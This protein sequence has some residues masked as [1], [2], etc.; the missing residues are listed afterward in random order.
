[1]GCQKRCLEYVL[2]DA[3]TQDPTGALH[4][5]EYLPLVRLPASRARCA[6]DSHLKRYA[7]GMLE[8][9]AACNNLA[10]PNV[11]FRCEGFHL[12]HI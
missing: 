10:C 2:S 11:L 12:F 1:M 8:I 4:N 6:D 9:R 3:K 7:S 5:A